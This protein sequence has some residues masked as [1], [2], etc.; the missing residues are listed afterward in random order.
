MKHDR[1]PSSLG[2]IDRVSGEV[3]LTD[4]SAEPAAVA[5]LADVAEARFLL[6]GPDGLHEG[7]GCRRRLV[8]G[9][10]TTLAARVDAFFA[11]TVPGDTP[12]VLV[13]ALPFDPAQHDHLY[14]PLRFSMAGAARM[15]GAGP[16]APLLD[17]EGLHARQQPTVSDYAHAVAECVARLRSVGG[18]SPSTAGERVAWRAASG[19]LRKVVLARSLHV[20]AHRRIDPF[21]LAARLDVDPAVTTFVASLPVANG[22]PP[23][24]LVGATP[25]LLVS[26]RGRAVLSHPL[27]G[28]ARRSADAQADRQ[29]AH[30]LLASDKDQNEHHFV[31]E[32]ILDGLSPLCT[33]LQAATQPSLHATATMWHLGTRI[34]GVLKDPDISA[35]ALAAI[36]HP[37]PAVCGTPSLPAL[38]TIRELEPEG[39]GFYAGAVGWSDAAGDGDWYVSIRCAHLQGHAM[40]LFAGAGIVAD[41]VPAL[42]VE[43]TSAKFM[44]MLNAMGI[45][46]N[47]VL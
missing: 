8:P 32:A 23:A 4:R 18:T 30:A 9:T 47:S 7:T 6:R 13:G 12:A 28:S 27:A 34:A 42:E 2:E 44:A 40:R 35:A 43:E 17:P 22:E 14:Q 11:E 33:R 31:V 16:S 39:R 26:R 1:R 15:Q 25:E 20:E 21:A 24:W 45:P 36:L 38:R 19:P 3:A 37:T 46:D 10:T 41:S 29:S 5:S